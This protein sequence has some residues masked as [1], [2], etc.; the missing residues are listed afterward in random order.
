[1]SVLE[2]SS[3]FLIVCG[4]GIKKSHYQCTCGMLGFTGLLSQSDRGLAKL[5]SVITSL[6]LAVLLSDCNFLTYEG[7]IIL[8]AV[9]QLYAVV[10][11]ED[12]DGFV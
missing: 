2:K 11:Q 7:L 6:K 12:M 10:Y 1:M 5:S 8:V 9:T 4:D 3:P